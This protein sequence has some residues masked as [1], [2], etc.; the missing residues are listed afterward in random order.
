MSAVIS[1]HK[2]VYRLMPDVMRHYKYF[3][4]LYECVYNALW[5]LGLSKV[6]SIHLLMANAIEQIN[7]FSG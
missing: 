1:I 6:L 7:Y 3:T 2:Y 5:V 4:T